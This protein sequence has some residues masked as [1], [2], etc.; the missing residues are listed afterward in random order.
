MKIIIYPL[1]ITT[2]LLTA[3]GIIVWRTLNLPQKSVTQTSPSEKNLVLPEGKVS[4][5]SDFEIKIKVPNT[6]LS[7]VAIRLVYQSEAGNIEKPTVEIN[8][9][10]AQENWTYPIKEA[11]I[12]KDQLVVD[13]AAVNLSPGGYLVNDEIILGKLNFP[14]T[15]LSSGKF[16]FDPEQTKVIAK[17]GQEINLGLK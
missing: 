6:T 4:L 12:S 16:T 3:L 13:L 14:G 7:A 8:Q 10:L 5:T 15:K 17:S 11:V 9:E 1:I 2:A